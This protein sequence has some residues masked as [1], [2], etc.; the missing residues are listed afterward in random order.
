MKIAKI[1][2]WIIAKNIQFEILRCSFNGFRRIECV[3]RISDKQKF[4]IRVLYSHT[5]PDIQ[6][7][8]IQE[9]CEDLINIIVEVQ[10]RSKEYPISFKFPINAIILVNGVISI[11]GIK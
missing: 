3:E 4:W 11:P 10:F 1:K 2:D 6:R 8:V 9:F 7:F 5:N